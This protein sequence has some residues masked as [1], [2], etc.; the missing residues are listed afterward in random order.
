MMMLPEMKGV[1]I[2]GTQDKERVILNLRVNK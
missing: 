2:P 1:T